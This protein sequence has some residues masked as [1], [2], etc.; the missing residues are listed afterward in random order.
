MKRL[1]GVYTHDFRKGTRLGKIHLSVVGTGKTICGSIERRN[2]VR[3][4]SG[5][6]YSK[7]WIANNYRDI[8]KICLKAS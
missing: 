2:C 3:V 6:W 5:N 7:K 8:C 4:E 1:I